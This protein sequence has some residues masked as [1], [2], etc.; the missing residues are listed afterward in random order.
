M[1]N[2][3][4]P[5]GGLSS[6]TS[7]AK[8]TP[9]QQDE[10]PHW[11]TPTAVAMDSNPSLR[12]PT[13]PAPE[14]ALSPVPAPAPAADVDPSNVALVDLGSRSLITEDLEKALRLWTRPAIL[15]AGRNSL[16]RLPANVP[17]TILYLDLSFNRWERHRLVA[18][19]HST[20]LNQRLVVC[21]GDY[22]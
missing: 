5:A 2:H 13:W 7:Y 21:V 17:Q 9:H 8:Q 6:Y 12:A 18:A 3:G 10:T 16:D 11:S 20:I 19:E 22:I 15:I 4:E 1:G 14:P